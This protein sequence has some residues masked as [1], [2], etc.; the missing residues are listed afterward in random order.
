M[1]RIW[2]VFALYASISL[3]TYAE[4][5]KCKC[6]QVPFKPDP[7]CVRACLVSLMKNADMSAL[8]ANVD[9]TENQESSLEMY[10]SKPVGDGSDPD[11]AVNQVEKKL[12]SLP[13][14]Q[15][16]KLIMTVPL[17]DRTVLVP[18]DQL[19]YYKR[20]KPPAK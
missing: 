17:T 14:D 5:I 12:Y 9:L 13:G 6:D 19:E 10:R 15:L 18:V 4:D 1:N 16:K 20:D 8:T 3:Q 2:G 7:P 11:E